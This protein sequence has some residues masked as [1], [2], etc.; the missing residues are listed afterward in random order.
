MPLPPAVRYRLVRMNAIARRLRHPAV[1]GSLATLGLLA[2]AIPQYLRHPEWRGQYEPAVDNATGD[3]SPNLD[4]LSS[5]D[6]ADLAEIDNLALLLNQLQPVTSTALDVDSVDTSRLDLPEATAEQVTTSPFAQYLERYRLRLGPT[7]ASSVANAEASS[8][9]GQPQDAETARPALP[10]S[11]LQQAL[12]QRLSASP[13]AEP[14]SETVEP[15]TPS[16]NQAAD[17]SGL[18]P[19][20]WMVEGSVPGVDQRFIRT[21]PQMSPPP[22][23]TGYRVPP[24]L[25]P[26]IVSPAIPS[27]ATVDFDLSNPAVAPA[28][29][30]VRSQPTSPTSTFN[31]TAPQTQPGP[32]PFSAP[33]P[34]GVYTGNGYINTFAD[35][36]GPV[37]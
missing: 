31:T 28:A 29:G 18:T 16:S 11:P 19:T 25:A 35:P 14:N 33:R 3:P 15:A 30:A 20:P 32:A 6:L 1:A 4:A 23:T 2:I 9:P 7:S 17:P 26:A 22:G 36:S 10:L 24:G 12:N 5:E 37:D 13:D 21:T 8:T 27:S 34:P